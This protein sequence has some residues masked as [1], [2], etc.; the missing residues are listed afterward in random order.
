MDVLMQQWWMNWALIVLCLLRRPV[1]QLN[2]VEITVQHEQ[3]T[4]QQIHKKR[5]FLVLVEVLF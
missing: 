4:A 5:G 3:I 1:L 2:I